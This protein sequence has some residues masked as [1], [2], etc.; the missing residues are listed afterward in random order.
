METLIPLEEENIFPKYSKQVSQIRFY[1]LH[2]L[3][4]VT[5][6]LGTL[7]SQQSILVMIYKP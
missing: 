4:L 7:S 6:L 5:D 1:F 3:C 2:I